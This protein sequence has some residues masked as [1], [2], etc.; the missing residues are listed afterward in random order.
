[1][2]VSD[3]LTIT[4]LKGHLYQCRDALAEPIFS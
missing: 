3:D 2:L 1:M 4:I